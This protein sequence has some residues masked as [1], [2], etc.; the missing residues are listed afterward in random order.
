VVF[1]GT[2]TPPVNSATP[3]VTA[4]YENQGLGAVLFTLTAT[5]NLTAKENV[6][7]FYFNFDDSL[8][9][10]A[11]SFSA[12]S[13]LGSFDLPSWVFSKNSLQADGDGKYDIRLD[14]RQGGNISKTFT[15]GD[16]VSYLLTYGGAESISEDSFKFFS[17]PAGGKGP[18]LVAAHVQ[19][20]TDGGSAWLASESV[21]TT[22]VPEPTTSALLCLVSLAIIARNSRFK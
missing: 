18:F 3:W 8:Q 15:Q 7:F 6:R 1:D 4:T 14:F 13:S 10:P 20:T 5:P 17:Q 19:N 9:L 22:S 2:T 16:S 12:V 11:L 21:S